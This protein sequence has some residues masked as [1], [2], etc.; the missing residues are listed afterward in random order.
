MHSSSSL[1]WAEEGIGQKSAPWRRK[2]EYA[3]SMLWRTLT[4]WISLLGICLQNT[5][6]TPGVDYVMR[7]T[8]KYLEEE[9]STTCIYLEQAITWSTIWRL[10]Q[11]YTR[12]LR[13]I[14]SRYFR[15]P[16]TQWIDTQGA[17]SPM[18]ILR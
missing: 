6:T 3:C 1:P 5:G 14:M 12:M 9:W 15:Y 11:G 7:N 16:D 10:W 17:A 2:L 8:F 13:C 18:D 4:D